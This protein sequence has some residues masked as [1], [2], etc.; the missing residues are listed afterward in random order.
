VAVLGVL[1][2]GAPEADG[3]GLAAFTIATPPMAIMPTDRRVVATIQRTP[4][5]WRPG[6]ASG[7]RV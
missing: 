3:A 5:K 1:V 7:S 6:W 4:V 2:L